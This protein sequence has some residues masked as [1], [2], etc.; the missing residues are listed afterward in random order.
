VPDAE[1]K[2]W[3]AVDDKGVYHRFGNSNDGTM[4][5]NGDSVQNGGFPVPAVVQKRLDGLIK[6]KRQ[7][8]L[9]VL[10]HMKSNIEI[11]T[12]RSK[13]GRYVFVD[14]M[15]ISIEDLTFGDEDAVSIFGLIVGE[16]DSL[17]ENIDRQESNAKFAKRIFSQDLPATY[18]FDL[19]HNACWKDGDWPISLSGSLLPPT[20]YIG[21]PGS[22]EIFDADEAYF[23]TLDS[24]SALL[25]AKNKVDDTIA[26]IEM[27]VIDY[28]KIWEQSKEILHEQNSKL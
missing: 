22:N 19:L 20:A 6:D 16:I 14:R 25:L 18:F 12:R 23:I 26:K 17:L 24:A 15:L 1:G 7:L 4:H 28:K 13:D 27:N 3:Y 10:E 8:N 21:L 9:T 5:W 2:H 11:S